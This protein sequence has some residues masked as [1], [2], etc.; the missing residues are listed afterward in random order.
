M[1]DVF[2]GSVNPVMGLALSIAIVSDQ[3]HDNAVSKRGLLL[4]AY[5]IG[6]RKQIPGLPGLAHNG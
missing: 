2:I 3:V 1:L 4:L 5:L 6:L